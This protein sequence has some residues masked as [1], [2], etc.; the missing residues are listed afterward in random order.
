[1]IGVR[2]RDTP[3]GRNKIAVAGTKPRCGAGFVRVT[4]IFRRGHGP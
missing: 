3:E 1:M 4:L 2:R